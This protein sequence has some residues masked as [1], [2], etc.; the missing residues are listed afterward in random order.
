MKKIITT[1]ALVA[2]LGIAS[3]SYAAN[4]NVAALS[5]VKSANNKVKVTLREGLG[6][7]RV[8]VLNND[9]KKLYVQTLFVKHDVILPIDLSELPVGEYHIMIEDPKEAG[10]R[11][12][13]SVETKAPKVTYPLMAYRKQLDDNSFKLTVIGLDKPGVKVQIIDRQGYTVFEEKI[14]EPEAFSKVYHLSN[15]YNDNV[16]VKVVDSDGRS[17]ILFE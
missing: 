7:V 5:E 13:T 8:S 9:G 1:I 10:D 16:F 6:K 4:E 17:K 3:F 12:I 2:S 15:L 11:T 14:N